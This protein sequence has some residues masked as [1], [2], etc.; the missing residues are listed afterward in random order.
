MEQRC[1]CGA[2]ADFYC[3]QSRRHLCDAHHSNCPSCPPYNQFLSDLL[4]KKMQEGNTQDLQIL[5]DFLQQ[6]GGLQIRAAVN[7]N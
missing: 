7:N 6:I 5:L 3:Q 4:N 1:E 2:E